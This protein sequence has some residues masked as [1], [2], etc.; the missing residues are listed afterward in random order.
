MRRL[1][2]VLVVCSVSFPVG[3]HFR[4]DTGVSSLLSS[5][6]LSSLSS[7]GCS[8]LRRCSKFA[9]VCWASLAIPLPTLGKVQK[10]WTEHLR[11]K[12]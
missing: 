8:H 10:V 9:S 3:I 11:T 5:L 4:G 12:E 2:A 7:V 6:L 1:I